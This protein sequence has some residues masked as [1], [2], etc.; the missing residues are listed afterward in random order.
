MRRTIYLPDD[1]AAATDEYLRRHPEH[2]F[3]SLVREAL[4]ER[5]APPDIN[6]LLELAGIVKKTR[7]RRRLQPEDQVALRDR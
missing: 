6:A 7:R 1:L 4:Q 3:S 5:V 2:T